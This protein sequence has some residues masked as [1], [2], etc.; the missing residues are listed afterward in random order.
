MLT[1]ALL[2]SLCDSCATKYLKETRRRNNANAKGRLRY[3]FA[4][5]SFHMGELLLLSCTEMTVHRMQR[6][7]QPADVDIFNC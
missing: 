2:C 1:S 6:A 7:A 3:Q 5:V 4:T